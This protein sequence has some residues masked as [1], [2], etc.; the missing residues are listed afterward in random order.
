MDNYKV[1]E[2]SEIKV[3]ISKGQEITTVPKVIGMKKE[4]AIKALEDANL[5]AE[6]IEETNKE[7]EAGYVVSQETKEN[8]EINAGETVKI[9]VSTGIEQV[10][11]PYVIGKTEAEARK[12]IQDA[13]LKVKQVIYEEDKTKEDGKVIKQDKEA[14]SALDEGTEIIITVNKI[15]QLK[16]GTV[17]INMKSLTGG[18]DEVNTITGSKTAKVEIKVGDDSVFK[19]TKSKNDTFSVNV[20]GIGTI[21]VKIY[22][23]DILKQTKQ[24]NLNSQREIVF[25]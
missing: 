1:K 14:G 20:N 18:Y 23:D 12:L 2:N 4:D 19:E 5:I 3:V 7:V 22:I 8:T 17:K 9:H 24:F 6:V 16:T 15:E 21:T 25:E 11:M 13:K 10:S